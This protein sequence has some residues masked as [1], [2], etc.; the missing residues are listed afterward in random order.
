MSGEERA[1]AGGGQTAQHF[2]EINSRNQD[3]KIRVFIFN[4]FHPKG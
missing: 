4:D 3:F 2:I 1:G